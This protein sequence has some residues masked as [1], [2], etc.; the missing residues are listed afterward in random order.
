MGR[1]VVF[2][3]GLGIGLDFASNDSDDIAP[4]YVVCVGGRI[5]LFS[6]GYILFV[7]KNAIFACFVAFVRDWWFG[8][9]LFCRVVWQ[10]HRF[11]NRRVFDVKKWALCPFF[12]VQSSKY[13]VQMLYKYKKASENIDFQ[14]KLS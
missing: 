9:L 6:W 14:N 12:K 11:P 13:R 4:W 8:V 1:V 3:H 2:N 7:A 5:V 10:Y